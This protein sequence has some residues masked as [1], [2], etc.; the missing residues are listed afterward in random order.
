MFKLLKLLAGPDSF[1]LIDAERAQS[2]V[3]T[4][5]PSLLYNDSN[6]DRECSNCWLAATWFRN[7]R[8]LSQLFH[9]RHFK[10]LSV[11]TATSQA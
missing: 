2:P 11:A 8:S 10:I 7:R 1:D 6:S 4:A 5:S 3:V 9:V